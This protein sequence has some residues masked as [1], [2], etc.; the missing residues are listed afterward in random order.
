[1]SLTPPPALWWIVGAVALVIVAIVGALQGGSDRSSRAPET[2]A[3]GAASRDGSPTSTTPA[4]AQPAANSGSPAATL[5]GAATASEDAVVVDPERGLMWTALDN[6][7]E[8]DWPAADGYCRALRLGGHTDWRLP[9]TDEAQSIYDPDNLTGEQRFPSGSS[10]PI[11]ASRGFRIAHSAIWTARRSNGDT[12]G[13]V[14]L[15]DGESFRV[16][17]PGLND[18][19]LAAVCLRPER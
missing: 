1:V 16:R 8:V 6:G 17:G 18:M 12:A 2:E 15:T 14:R 11:H 13:F 9:T 19:R 4:S 3:S 10:L 7:A 5:R